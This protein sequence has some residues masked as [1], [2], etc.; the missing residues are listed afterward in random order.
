MSI[1]LSRYSAVTD[2]VV[3]AATKILKD[4]HEQKQIEGRPAGAELR[5]NLPREYPQN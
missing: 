3:A 5:T 1:G 2:M 4:L